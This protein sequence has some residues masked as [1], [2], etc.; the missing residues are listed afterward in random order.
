MS[1][2]AIV[3]TCAHADPSASNER[4][5]WLGQLIYDI[6]PDYVID[7]GDG[8][9]MRSLN[10]YD[11]RY[12]Q[13]IVS[14]SYEEDI[15]SYNDSQ[16][17]LRWKFRHHKRKRPYWIGFEGNHENRIKKAISLDP[18]LEG[19]RYGVSFSHL[20]TSHWFD[21]Y[22]EYNNGGPALSSYDGVLYGHFVSGGNYGTA[23][24]GLHHA[25]TLITATTCSTTVG[26][27]HKF[28]YK[29][30]GGARPTPIHGLV[31]GCFKGKEERWAGQANDEWRYGVVI[32]RE[33]SNGDYNLQWVSMQ[34]LAKEYGNGL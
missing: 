22:H 28:D 10:S 14:Q 15:E 23:L 19:Q 12:P 29:F 9:D 26:H 24:S 31:A 11:T 7:L 3:Y 13:D 33:L 5:D 30:K 8:A 4:F 21:D 6:R 34:Q 2:T 18:R 17:R 20:Q 32:K 1:K 27:S 16:E 25:N